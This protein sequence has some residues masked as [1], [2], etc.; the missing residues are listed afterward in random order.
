MCSSVIFTYFWFNH[1]FAFNLGG[2]VIVLPINYIQNWVCNYS[3]YGVHIRLFFL[4]NRTVHHF[5]LTGIIEVNLDLLVFEYQTYYYLGF[6]IAFH[7][8]EN[9]YFNFINIK[10]WFVPLSISRNLYNM[11]CA[12]C[13]PGRDLFDF[14]EFHMV[15]ATCIYVY[16]SYEKKLL[17]TYY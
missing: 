1:W 11:I 14:Y 12:F 4:P 17:P 3:P 9:I 13:L 5:F 2:C 16:F 7:W 6:Q 8:F 15:M 10:K